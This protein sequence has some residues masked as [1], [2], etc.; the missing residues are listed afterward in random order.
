MN[1]DCA[2]LQMLDPDTNELV[3]RVSK[4]RF[5]DG[6]AVRRIPTSISSRVVGERIAI[7]TDNA[8]A[9]VRFQGSSIVVQNV[10]SAMCTPLMGRDGTV[11]G[12]FYVDNR[13]ANRAF[14][15]DDL[16]FL[17]AFAGIAA[18]AIENTKAI[19]QSELRRHLAPDVADSLASREAAD[20]FPSSQQTITVLAA[21]LDGLGIDAELTPEERTGFLAHY[22][23]E[24]ME[25]VFAN[26]G[27]FDRGMTGDVLAFWGLP[28]LCEDA[29]ARAL[30][31]A[32]EIQALV[33][34][35]NKRWLEKGTLRVTVRIGVASGT[36]IGQNIG[37]DKRPD[38]AVVGFPLDQARLLCALASPGEIRQSS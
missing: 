25:I 18:A 28:V 24:A 2:S 13:T 16:S 14:T 3:P 17:I 36:A 12:V 34:R 7:L 4:S 1:V 37:T 10:R 20:A 38:Y 5:A 29:S 8:E 11:L 15:D 6:I 23:K 19:Q 9:D 31:T 26:A 33:D 27:T 35:L 21:Q 30:E 32:A 22:V